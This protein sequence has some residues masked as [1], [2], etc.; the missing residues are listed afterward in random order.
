MFGNFMKEMDK[1][2]KKVSQGID[3][4]SKK[5]EETVDQKWSSYLLVS[6]HIYSMV[7]KML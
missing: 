5:I 1:V 2:G 7:L 6:G 3:S 4:A